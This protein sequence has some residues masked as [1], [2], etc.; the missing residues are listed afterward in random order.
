MSS[1]TTGLPADA[2]GAD[3]LPDPDEVETVADLLAAMRAARGLGLAA[4]QV[5]RDVRV[6]VVEAEGAQLVLLNPEIVGRR[7]LQ[8]GWEGCLSVPD[9]VAL[10][11]RPAELTV[12]GLD[13]A[14]RPFRRRCTGLLAR[15]VAHEVDHLA[16][17]LYVDLVPPEALV[18]VREHPTPLDTSQPIS[19]VTPDEGSR[20]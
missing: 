11:D 9:L 6:A 20:P 8:R 4:P 14:G 16:G 18:D 17:R 7:G 19:T 5:G 13:R 2:P 12:A 15:A 1:D 10:V 3:P